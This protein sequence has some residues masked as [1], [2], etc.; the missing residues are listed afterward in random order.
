[1]VV[2]GEILYMEVTVVLF[3]GLIEDIPRDKIRNLSENVASNIQIMKI[4]GRKTTQ[5][6]TKKK[7]KDRL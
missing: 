3:Y 6:K 2:T 5:N 1:M 7:I 4:L